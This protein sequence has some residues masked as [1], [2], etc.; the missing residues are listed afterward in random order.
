MGKQDAIELD[1]ISRSETHVSQELVGR[2]VNGADR[3]ARV[4]CL[5]PRGLALHNNQRTKG[6]AAQERLLDV[7]TSAERRLLVNMMVRVIA[8]NQQYSRPGAGRRRGARLLHERSRVVRVMQV[9]SQPAARLTSVQWLVIAVACV[10]FAFDLS[11]TFPMA[12]LVRP[13]I[14]GVG[15]A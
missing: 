1:G 9:L 7:L 11:E 4:L 6:R 14:T 15:R 12:L 10:A 8:A 13:A 2:H 3:R 5:T